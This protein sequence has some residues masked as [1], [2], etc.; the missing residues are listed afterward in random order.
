MHLPQG[1]V[2]TLNGKH[3]DSLYMEQSFQLATSKST[4]SFS[5]REKTLDGIEDGR[6]G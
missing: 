1:D 3:S 6:N 4:R 2:G 5:A